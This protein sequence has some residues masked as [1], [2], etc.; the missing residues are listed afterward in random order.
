MTEADRPNESP[1]L[2]RDVL[3]HYVSARRN[4]YAW[5]PSSAAIPDLSIPGTKGFAYPPEEIE[6]GYN[7]PYRYTDEWVSGKEKGAFSGREV[8]FSRYDEND[9]IT[10]YS[11]MGG[12]T[13][14]GIKHG[15]GFVYGLLLRGFLRMHADQVRLGGNVKFEEKIEQGSAAYKGEGVRVGRNWHDVEKIE[16]NGTLLYVA[17]G[18]GGYNPEARKRAIAKHNEAYLA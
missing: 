10:W 17:R 12:L 16:L 3:A 8:N 6:P 1:I 5:M 7:L 15:E 13:E 18:D 2:P 9:L 11:Y 4:T 14:E